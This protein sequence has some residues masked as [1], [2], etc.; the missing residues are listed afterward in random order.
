MPSA[1]FV[2]T[3]STQSLVRICC[4]RLSRHITEV[5]A[6]LTSNEICTLALMSQLKKLQYEVIPSVAQLVLFP[7]KLRTLVLNLSKLN[8]VAINRAVQSIGRLTALLDL[9]IQL[10]SWLAAVSFAPLS[11]C[12]ALTNLMF[13]GP[14]LE[15]PPMAGQPTDAHIDQLR[16]RH[17]LQSVSIVGLN[18]TSLTKLLRAPHSRMDGALA[19]SR[20]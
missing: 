7:P 2:Q 5:H 6:K 1:D 18:T 9:T 15:G 16:A 3:L 4:S 12:A 8:A 19:T 10:D 17:H 14:G 11:N 20:H 13:K